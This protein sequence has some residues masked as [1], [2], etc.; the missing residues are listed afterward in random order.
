MIC[1]DG[2]STWKGKGSS[3]RQAGVLAAAGLIALEQS[4]KRLHED[5]ENAQVLAQGLAAIPGTI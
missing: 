4:P 1:S 3:V 2:P 5:H